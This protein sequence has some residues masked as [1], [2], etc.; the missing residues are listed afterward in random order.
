VERSS[1]SE[2]N[3]WSRMQRGF[4]SNLR[5]AHGFNG[6]LRKTMIDKFDRD[7]ALTFYGGRAFFAIDLALT[8][9]SDE[10]LR[11]AF[12][13]SFVNLWLFFREALSGV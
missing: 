9:I 4:C 1:S 11:F 13:G 5:A 2:T 6:S 3:F 8:L 7:L 12:D 10:L